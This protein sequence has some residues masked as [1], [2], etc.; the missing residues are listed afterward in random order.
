MK[1][2]SQGAMGK[3]APIWCFLLI[4]LIGC[5]DTNSDWNSVEYAE[6]NIWFNIDDTDLVEGGEAVEL[7]FVLTAEPENFVDVFFENPDGQVEFSPEN[8]FRVNPEDW[9]DT[10]KVDITATADRLEEESIHTGALIVFSESTDSDYNLNLTG[11]E[12]IILNILDSDVAGLSLPVLP[13]I[14][15]ELDDEG[16]SFS[17]NLL[18]QPTSDVVVSVSLEFTDDFISFEPYPAIAIFAPDNWN[19][20]QTFMVFASE[21]NIH[22]NN[23]TNSFIFALESDDVYYD[24]LAVEP[25]AF[26]IFDSSSEP[27][28]SFNQNS[29]DYLTEGDLVTFDFFIVLEGSSVEEVTFSLLSVPNSNSPQPGSDFAPLPETLVF[30]PGETEMTV[31]MEII[32][33]AEAEPDETGIFYLEALENCLVEGNTVQVIIIFMDDD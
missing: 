5:D 18:S 19:T 12:P 32:N 24:S 25:V 20:P 16:G 23:R 27:R 4:L 11:S 31:T 29:F 30:S 15:H 1:N 6:K 14:I 33:D 8:T 7:S 22:G 10:L 28:I 9:Q 13:P 17:I 21:D 2:F 3:L 26:E